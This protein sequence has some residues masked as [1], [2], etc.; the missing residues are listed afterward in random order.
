MRFA[1]ALVAFLVVQA[2]LRAVASPGGGAVVGSK[3]EHYTRAADHYDTV[4]IGTSHVYR[5]FVPTEF[6]RL[7]REEGREATSFNFGIQLPNQVELHYLLRLALAEGKGHLRRVF[8]QY[9]GL[10]PQ[11]DPDQ[12]FIAR[13]VYWHDGEGTVLA[14]ERGWVIDEETPGGIHLAPDS[15][16]EHAVL[17]I[18]ER[19]L[20]SRYYLARQHFQHFVKREMLVARGKDVVRGILGRPYAMTGQWRADQGYLS[21]EEDGARLAAEGNEENFILRR[22]QAFLD[23]HDDYL[24]HVERLRTEDVVWGDQEWMNAEVARFSDLGVYR[25]MAEDARAAGVE[26]IIVIM[27]SNSCDRRFEEGMADELGVPLLRYNLPDRYPRFYD[28]ALRYDSGHLT[29][30][31]ALEF[32]RV[33]AEEYLTLSSGG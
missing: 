13:N 30:E 2:V 7:L 1:I 27:P 21:L 4:F 10:M 32:T 8:V 18:I 16:R 25:A 12:A 29:A 20:P 26:L 24:A 9:Y 17:A 14:I 15:K 11:V 28:P 3:V 19:Q 23:A 6:D 31:G 33:L 22:R 5:S